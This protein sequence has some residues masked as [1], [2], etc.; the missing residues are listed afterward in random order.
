MSAQGT[1]KVRKE[2]YSVV[3][4]KHIPQSGNDAGGKP[5]CG[6]NACGIHAGVALVTGIPD[7]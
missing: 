1:I 7:G 6:A 2:V 4:E 5:I 3:L